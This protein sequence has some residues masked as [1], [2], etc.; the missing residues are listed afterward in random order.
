MTV[1]GAAAQQHG[2]MMLTALPTLP[3]MSPHLDALPDWLP[4]HWQRWTP[5][6]LTKPAPDL[7]EMQDAP[8]RLSL[9]LERCLDLSPSASTVVDRTTNWYLIDG[10]HG[11]AATLKALD[12]EIRAARAAEA[13]ARKLFFA[14]QR[15]TVHMKDTTISGR[16]RA[17]RLCAPLNWAQ[18]AANAL[19]LATV[20]LLVLLAVRRATHALR[21]R[22]AVPPPLQIP[23]APC[24][25][26]RLQGTR[27][28]RAPQ[29]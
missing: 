29:S 12:R 26:A 15:V 5:F 18:I 3:G 22:L 2:S 17:Y 25:V 23:V 6:G 8:K 10:Q 11:V 16:V 13:Q 14:S 9:R 27:V 21:V 1:P 19:A 24:A 4:L 20:H 28:P 7:E